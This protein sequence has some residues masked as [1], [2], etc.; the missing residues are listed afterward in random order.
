MDDKDHFGIISI[1]LIDDKD[2]YGINSIQ[3][4]DDKDDNGV[5]SIDLIYDKDDYGII[6]DEDDI[7]SKCSYHKKSQYD[8]S[9]S[10]AIVRIS[11]SDA[12][13]IL[14]ISKERQYNIL[15]FKDIFEG[16]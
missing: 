10:V 9:L 1:D 3:Y 13:S 11:F 8:I 6:D 4:I 2:D 12:N 5:I 7:M 16:N 14:V 15:L